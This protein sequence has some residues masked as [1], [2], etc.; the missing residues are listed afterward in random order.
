MV[1]K[2][3]EDLENPFWRK[4][5]TGIESFKNAQKR[6]PE[7]TEFQKLLGD[8]EK[9]KRNFDNNLEIGEK[10]V[11]KFGFSKVELYKV[12]KNKAQIRYKELIENISSG[13]IFDSQSIGKAKQLCKKFNF[14]DKELKKAKALGLENKLKEFLKDS[15][16]ESCSEL[17]EKEIEDLVNLYNVNQKQLETFKDDVILD[18]ASNY[19]SMLENGKISEPDVKSFFDKFELPNEDIHR[20][21]NKLMKSVFKEID[22]FYKDGSNFQDIFIK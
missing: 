7:Y 16:V 12:A 6:H 13:Y 18:I 21:S 5:L 15:I 10:L 11:S 4:K 17:Y 1:R 19:I 20:A 22:G 14:S 8:L 3:G 2:T 9:E